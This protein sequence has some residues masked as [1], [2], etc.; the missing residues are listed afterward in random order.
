MDHQ[1]EESH[2]RSTAV[3]EFDGALLEFCSLV[4]RLPAKVNGAVAEVSNVFVSSAGDALHDGN[5][6]QAHKGQNLEGTGGG[7][8]LTSSPSG[9]DVGELGAIVRD[10]A[11][12]SDTSGGDKVPHNAEHANAAVLDLDVPEAVELG[13][14]AVGNDAQRIPEAER[15]LDA[16]LIREGA[17]LQ[18]R[19][20][21]GLLGRGEGSRGGDEGGSDG[22]LHGDWMLEGEENRKWAAQCLCNCGI[23][24]I[25]GIRV[26]VGRKAQSLLQV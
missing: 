22:E 16:Y 2:L 17:S 24:K 25:A 26:Q 20:L 23:G 21:A 4:K 15:L 1:G 7:D 6:Q 12:Q 18:G 13:L 11:R 3:V 10:E 5:L 9:G 19:G 8:R 14:V